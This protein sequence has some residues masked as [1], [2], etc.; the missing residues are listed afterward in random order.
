MSD[1]PSFEEDT[2]I[3]VNVVKPEPSIH[4]RKSIPQKYFC[5]FPKCD[6]KPKGYNRKLELQNH[7]KVHF[8]MKVILR[9]AVLLTIAVP[10]AKRI[11]DDKLGY[12]ITPITFSMPE[13][14]EIDHIKKYTVNLKHKDCDELVLRRIKK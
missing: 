9:D 11:F 8:N 3:S 5:D 12:H 7:Y 1:I 10:R 2:N 4:E 13:G 6:I 14:F